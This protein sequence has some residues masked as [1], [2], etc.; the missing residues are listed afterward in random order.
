MLDF[1]N[2]TNPLTRVWNHLDS[3]IPGFD[4]NSLPGIKPFIQY[5]H[6]GIKYARGEQRWSMIMML[7]LD[8]ALG[9]MIHF[10]GEH[11]KMD[12]LISTL[13][14]YYLFLAN[15]LTFLTKALVYK[16]FVKLRPIRNLTVLRR[17]IKLV[18]GK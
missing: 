7:F 8:A 10:W 15:F 6:R 12:S 5:P 13:G 18:F 2:F 14:M 1:I 3:Q 17:E 16:M 9:L 11:Y 4:A